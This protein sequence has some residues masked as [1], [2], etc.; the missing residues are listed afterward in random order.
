MWHPGFS[1]VLVG[2]MGESTSVPSFQ[3]LKS[4]VHVYIWH[5][6]RVEVLFIPP[7]PQGYAFVLLPF[8]EKVVLFPLN[9]LALLS[10]I[11]RWVLFHFRKTFWDH[12][13]NVSSF[14][15]FYFF[16]FP[17]IPVIQMLIYLSSVSLYP[18]SFW[19][20]LPCFTLFLLAC[21]TSIFFCFVLFYYNFSH[22][23]FLFD[24]LWFLRLS[25][26]S[27]SLH[28]SDDFFFSFSPEFGQLSSLM[29][30]FPYIFILSF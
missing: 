28:F 3:E 30:G 24:F 23:S 7:N 25:C 18:W 29:S 10:K 20:P 8:V 22:V 14:P 26:L 4:W 27:L 11:N 6:L 15:L 21:L 19:K 16:F 12:W 9:Y 13:L 17:D 2:W 1:V 5:E